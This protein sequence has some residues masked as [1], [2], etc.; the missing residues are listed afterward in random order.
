M[1]RKRT[2]LARPRRSGR[3]KS[4]KLKPDVCVQQCDAAQPSQHCNRVVGD[5]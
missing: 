2:R 1:V 5:T 3:G 4:K